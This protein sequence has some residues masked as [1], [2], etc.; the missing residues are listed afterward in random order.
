MLRS[1]FHKAE[2]TILRS[3]K[4][5]LSDIL[6]TSRSQHEIDIFAKRLA[7]K[8]RMM[9]V[10][11]IIEDIVRTEDKNLLKVKIK[12]GWSEDGL[13]FLIDEKYISELFDPDKNR[14]AK[15]DGVT[16]ISSCLVECNERIR[17][18]TG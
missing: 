9:V 14:V 13:I 11:G 6:V 8:D 15:S 5:K 18:N 16:R 4:I 12:T 2:K 17:T 7:K 10:F 3:D 1:V